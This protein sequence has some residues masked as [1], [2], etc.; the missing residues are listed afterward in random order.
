MATIDTY[1]KEMKDSGASDLH[2]VIG[3]P[4]LLRQRGELVP[5]DNPVLTQESNREILFDI[6]TPDQQAHLAKNCLN[7]CKIFQG[8]YQYFP[9]SV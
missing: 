7:R 8:G 2:M 9:E 5:L 3:F 1:F 4:P 6:L